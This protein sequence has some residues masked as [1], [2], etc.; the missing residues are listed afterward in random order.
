[1][2][3]WRTSDIM[4]VST[5]IIEH[6]L[7][8]NH[9]AKPSKQRLHKMLDE[10][11]AAAKAEV[12]RF[13]C[14]VH[15]PS[16]LVNVVMVKKKNGKWRM[17]TDF[18][19]LNRCCLKDDFPLSRIDKVVDSAAGCET[20]ALLDCFS[21]FHQIWLGKEDEEKTS[22]ITPFGTYC[23]LRMPEGL[24]NAGPRFCRMIK[25]ILKEQME[26]NVFTYID[27]IVVAS[28]KKE[29]QIHD[30]AETFANLR[31]AQLK[32]NPEK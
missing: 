27:D 25:A 19:V 26:I 17:C 10:K 5:A 11:L 13:I 12:A 1:V 23:Y 9:S 20:I 18:T 30:L 32:L 22:F 21:G 28:R 4:G 6:K 16:W 24:N 8:V 2:F 14:E 29:N 7:Q 15:Y 3:A 31:G